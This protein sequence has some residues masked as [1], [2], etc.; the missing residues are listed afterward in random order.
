[1]PTT[2]MRFFDDMK[3]AGKKIGSIAVV[4]ENTDYGTSVADAVEA[5][6]KENKLPVAIRIPYSGEHHGCLRA[7]AAAQGEEPRRRDLH[8]LHGGLDPLHQDHEE[9]RL[10]AADGAGRRLRILRSVIRA[11]ESPISGRG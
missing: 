10:P 11:G 8:Q 6:A 9:P 2:Y 7:G 3:K 5:A 4:N 1:M